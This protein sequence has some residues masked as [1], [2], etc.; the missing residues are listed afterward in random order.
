MI[1]PR[2][3]RSLRNDLRITYV[4]PSTSRFCDRPEGGVTKT[5]SII[6]LDAVTGGIGDIKS[7]AKSSYRKIIPFGFNSVVNELL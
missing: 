7:V 2:L 5:V 1:L 6:S 4:A 3:A